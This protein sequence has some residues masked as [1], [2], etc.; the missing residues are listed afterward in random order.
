MSGGT[1]VYKYD[2]SGNLLNQFSGFA[3]GNNISGLAFS[4]G[5]V[6]A[7][8]NVTQF[9]LSEVLTLDNNGDY[10]G[11]AFPTGAFP[12]NGIAANGNDIYV[13]SGTS[14]YEYNTSG[15]LL[16]TFNVPNASNNFSALA[17]VSPAPAPSAPEPASLAL[18]LTAL[19]IWRGQFVARLRAATAAP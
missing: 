17:A 14:I 5:N 10:T 19:A 18:C 3:A 7:I 13:S 15:S 4:D 8:D 12:L 1:S 16:N 11:A 6:Y 9:G 2:T